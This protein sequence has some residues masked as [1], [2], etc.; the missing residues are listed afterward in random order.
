M[1]MWTQCVCV[2][3]IATCG[4][5]LS[6]PEGTNGEVL[7][8]QKTIHTISAETGLEGEDEVE[9]TNE[10][11][12]AANETG[13]EEDTEEEGRKPLHDRELLARRAEADEKKRIADSKAYAKVRAEASVYSK[14]HAESLRLR[15]EARKKK[16]AAYQRYTSARRASLSKYMNDLSNVYSMKIGRSNARIGTARRIRREQWQAYTRRLKQEQFYKNYIME[17]QNINNKIKDEEAFQRREY[18]NYLRSRA[19][20]REQAARD[21]R[22]AWSRWVTEHAKINKEHRARLDVH[23]A[24]YQKAVKAYEEEVKRAKQEWDRARLVAQ[25]QHTAA[26]KKWEAK[27]KL[28]AKKCKANYDG[29]I[30]DICHEYDVGTP[31]KG[32]LSFDDVEAE[33]LQMTTKNGRRNEFKFWDTDGNDKISMQECQWKAK[34]YDLNHNCVPDESEVTKLL[35]WFKSA[36]F[37]DQFNTADANGDGLIDVVEF[38][39]LLK[40]KYNIN[41]AGCRVAKLFTENHAVYTGTGEQVKLNIYSMFALYVNQKIFKNKTWTF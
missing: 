3:W 28:I 13:N 35:G 36:L 5:S 10:I 9:A 32:Y 34:V 21:N 8:V 4:L 15:S 29:T 18:T 16:N 24:G 23:Y 30:K 19:T 11:L 6:N 39:N 41:I 22:V 26:A 33:A 1:A 25:Q 27:A 20:A 37:Q 7:L 40:K 31:P 38:V 14:N 12:G 17:D 2:I